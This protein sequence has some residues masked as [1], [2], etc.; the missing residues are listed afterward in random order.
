M[1]RRVENSQTIQKFTGF[2]I[3]IP[4]HL[5]NRTLL[6]RTWSGRMFSATQPLPLTCFH[7][8]QG[9]RPVFGQRE[10]FR[11]FAHSCQC[12]SHGHFPE[13]LKSFGI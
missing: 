5:Q 7:P 12:S 13:T 11:F 1:R 3:H 9:F 4:H 10:P 8:M 6:Q 2:F